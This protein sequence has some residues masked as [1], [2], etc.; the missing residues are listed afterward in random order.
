[1]AAGSEIGTATPNHAVNADAPQAAL[2]AV[3]RVAGYLSSLGRMSIRIAAVVNAALIALF[4]GAAV[5]LCNAV[6]SLSA[7]FLDVRQTEAQFFSKLIKENWEGIRTIPEEK[8]KVL[9]ENL[10]TQLAG[11]DIRIFRSLL[12][13][14]LVML[15]SLAV[16]DRVVALFRLWRSTRG[17]AHAP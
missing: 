8:K 15:C 9:V 6:D 14:A 12:I 1:M 7:T 5:Y 10:D 13:A 4:I 16:F 2:R 17:T 11:T 3:P